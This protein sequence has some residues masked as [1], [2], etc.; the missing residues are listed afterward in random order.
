M[1]LTRELATLVSADLPLDDS[2]R[3][4]AL[5]P[6]LPRNAQRLVGDLLER[7]L[8]GASLSEAL[9]EH[10]ESIPKIYCRLVAASESSGD[11]ASALTTLAADL[12]REEDLRSR[13]R[14]AL[15]Y[16]MTLLVAAAAT[17][18]LV[19][20]V[21]V[22]AIAPLFSE[23]GAKLPPVIAVLNAWR[24]GIINGWPLLV[25]VAVLVSILVAFAR[26]KPAF[27]QVRDRMVLRLPIIGRLVARRETSRF[28]GTLATLLGSGIPLLEAL[29]IT[30]DTQSNRLFQ[31]AVRDAGVHL[32]NGGTLSE[33]MERSGQFSALALRL[34]TVGER[35]GQ[36]D[37]MLLRLSRLEESALHRELERLIA[38]AAPVLT[39]AIGL[40]V[41]GIV[42]SV[43]G[44]IVGLNDLAFQ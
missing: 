3:I 31:V 36:L 34:A 28:G 2:L 33:A 32:A 41:G 5:Q 24:V 18:T 37:T 16:P 9:A 8:G 13:L 19:I 30:G 38:I 15:L 23:S 44:A 4:V 43:M 17:I 29:R 6:S 20:A 27:G 11:I 21:L 26:R 14:N 1:S 42:L 12:E 22:P 7:V 35:T 40:I 10:P 25:G 39:I